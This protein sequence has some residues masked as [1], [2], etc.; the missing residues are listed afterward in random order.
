ME[1]EANKYFEEIDRRG[2]VIECIE[3]GYLQREIAKAA[4]RFQR[5][6]EQGE[7]KIVGVS[8]FQMENERIE[9]DVLKIDRKVEQEQRD[10]VARIKAERDSDTAQQTL[11]KLRQ[12][13]RTETGNTFEAI[14]DC[15]RAYCTLGEMCDVLREEWGEY[16]EPPSAMVAS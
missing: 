6:I 5:E 15:C 12:V 1:R 10:F 14:M 9:I 11:E 8:D 13:S 7:R 16:V 3:E 2:G 4:Y